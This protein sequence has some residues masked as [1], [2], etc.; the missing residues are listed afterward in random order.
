MTSNP[1]TA[2]SEMYSQ[3]RSSLKV[4]S[5]ESVAYLLHLRGPLEEPVQFHV[6]AVDGE[7]ARGA[8]EGDHFELAHWKS[9]CAFTLHVI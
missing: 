9:V 4:S 3:H 2:V 6:V 8:G 7:V 5:D 1:I